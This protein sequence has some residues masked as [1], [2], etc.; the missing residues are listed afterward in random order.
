MTISSSGS[1]TVGEA[2]SLMCSATLVTPIP[3]PSNISSPT[4]E[5]LLNDS[6]GNASLPSGVTRMGTVM[7]NNTYTSTLQFSPLSLSHAGMYTCQ[8]GAG[9]LANST[10]VTVNGMIMNIIKSLLSYWI[11]H[12]SGYC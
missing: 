11:V 3:L 4:F 1:T 8:I 9:R 6:N 7:S 2:Y 10:M 5:W 12:L